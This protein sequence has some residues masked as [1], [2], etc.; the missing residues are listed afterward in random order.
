[1]EL[2]S[3]KSRRK[4]RILEDNCMRPLVQCSRLLNFITCFTGELAE[5]EEG[6][7]STDIDIIMQQLRV[8]RNTAV[9][10]LKSTGDVVDAMLEISSK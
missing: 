10:A 4:V 7:D 8:D 2:L 5:S 6:V 9:K 3:E 1:M